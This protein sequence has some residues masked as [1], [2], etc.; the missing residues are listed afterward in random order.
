MIPATYE[1][2][3]LA[4]SIPRA[5]M[6]DNMDEWLAIACT[7]RN[8]V[9]RYGKTYSEVLEKAEVNR[10][11]WVAINHPLLINPQNGLLAIIE[12]IYKNETPDFTSN[13]LV[14]DGAL[15]F[16]RPQNH[17]GTGDEFEEKILK[18]PEDH[19]LIGFWGLQGFY[20]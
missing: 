4:W 13:H 19:P 2:A 10:P 5:A 20:K 9:L 17:Q 8:R 11:R 1:Q 12:S 16:G 3:L 7:F 15:F 14:R 6:S 18:N